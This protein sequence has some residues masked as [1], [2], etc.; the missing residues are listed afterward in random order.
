MKKTLSLLCLSVGL[1]LISACSTSHEKEPIDYVNPYIGNIS[2]ML[3][4]TTPMQHLPA[5]MMRV[6]PMR[7][8]Y[9]DER[10]AGLPVL[11]T[12]D[13]G[14]F[15]F[16]FNPYQGEAQ[17]LRPIL[18]YSYDNEKATP[19]RYSVL[20]DW[21]GI[22]V[23]FAPSHQSALYRFSYE[24]KGKPYFIVSTQ[25]GHIE[26]QGDAFW[27][28]ELIDA[29]SGT[30]VYL[31]GQL[32]QQAEDIIPVQHTEKGQALAL[33]FADGLKQQQVRY[34]VSFISVEQA[35]KNLQR[36]IT[37]W[38]LDRLAL[39][40][41]ETWNKALSSIS[42]EGG[43]DDDKA[44]FYTALYR[45]LTRPVC[46]SEDDHYYSGFDGKVHDNDGRNFY[47]D[48]W[49]WDTYRTAHPLRALIDA[50]MESDILHSC[51]LMAEQM[52]NHWLPTFTASTGPRWWMNSNH[53]VASMIDGYRK[54]IR[55]FSL[56]KAFEYGKKGIEEKSLIPWYGGPAGELEAFYQE[57]GYIPA[58]RPGEPE[59]VKGV[60]TSWEKRQPVAVTLGTVYDEWCLAQLAQELGDTAQANHYLKR[61]YN[62]RTLFHPETHFFHPKD[63]DGQFIPDVSSKTIGRE[64]YCENNGYIHRWDVQHNFA[65]LVSLLGGNEATDRELDLLF[66][67]PI[68]MPRYN[69]YH[70]MPD[71]GANVGMFSMANEPCCHI[72][73]LYNYILRPWKTQK[74]VRKLLHDW[75]RNDL[76]GMPGD[77]D[78]GGMSGF[79]VFSM[80]GFYPTTPGLPMYTIGSPVFSD[81][82]IQLSDG[83][84]LQIKAHNASEENKYIQ[85]ARLNGKPLTNAWF[86]HA[87]IAQ[88]GLL[89]LEMSN[90]PNKQ[91]GT[92]EAPPSLG[93]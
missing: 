43:T 63:K 4:P 83:H 86:M 9:N 35:Q 6:N 48:D 8:G 7:E 51:I 61:S 41:R 88:G 55:G 93:M 65:D 74:L 16:S 87:D 23:D 31:Y 22:Q 37:D 73:Y 11:L 19:Y 77:E 39:A 20:L 44:V 49:I 28:E 46:M 47:T 29:A 84:T 21:P 36:E 68:G 90:R 85:S 32:Q 69:F 53:A 14:S 92:S 91:W 38:N 26:A 71:H 72:P 3:V 2:H 64:Y 59:T 13:R 78:G 81:I 18:S 75:F 54:G 5:S 56:E 24:G 25:N 82:K 60:N 45:C 12:N 33:A 10:L 67:T 50:Q 58:L 15:A 70:L 1:L 17:G 42:V 66:T 40:G 89:E 27:G 52:D 76:M 62:Y 80:I 79:V 34:G 30:K 57:H